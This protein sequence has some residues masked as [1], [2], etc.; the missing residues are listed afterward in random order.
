MRLKKS[1]LDAVQEYDFHYITI[2][3]LNCVENI[4]ATENK[5]N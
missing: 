1:Q 4:S 3:F 5:V 2:K